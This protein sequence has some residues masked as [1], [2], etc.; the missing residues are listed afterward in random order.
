[1]LDK[2]LAPFFPILVGESANL[3]RRLMY[4][5]APRLRLREH[6][7]DPL[8]DLAGVFGLR[9]RCPLRRP[10]AKQAVECAVIFHAGKGR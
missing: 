6:L 5:R 2:T 1:M 7:D 10:T 8:F 9:D 3:P 4:R